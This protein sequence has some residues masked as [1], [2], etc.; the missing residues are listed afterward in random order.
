MVYPYTTVQRA[1]S[2]PPVTIVNTVSIL[3]NENKLGAK[4]RQSLN[5]FLV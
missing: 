1:A 2:M 4:L 3:D 5:Q